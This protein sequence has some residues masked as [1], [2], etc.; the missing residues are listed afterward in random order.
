MILFIGIFW[1]FHILGENWIR[2]Y[3]VFGVVVE[4]C[5]FLSLNNWEMGR[6][7]CVFDFSKKYFSCYGNFIEKDNNW[8]IVLLWVN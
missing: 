1:L 5:D 4:I 2:G 6:V 8:K 3:F 7:Y